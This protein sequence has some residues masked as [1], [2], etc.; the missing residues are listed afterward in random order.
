WKINVVG[1]KNVSKLCKEFKAFLIYVSTDYVFKGDKGM[2]GEEEETDPINYY[3]FTK[4]EGEKIV[5]GLGEF[6]IART[7]VIYGSKPASGKTNFALWL[8]EKLRKEEAV[9]VVSDQ[10]NSPTLNTNLAEMLLEIAER[11]LSGIYHLAGATRM[12][13]Y[14]FAKLV[15]KTFDL[16]KDLIRPTSMESLNWVAKRPRD[17]SLNVSKAMRELR[18]KPKEIKLALNELKDEMAKE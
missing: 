13:R 15:A 4:L 16:S 1:T 3:G 7:S 18:N 6:C 2:Y 10:Y 8:I 5:K 14:E 11:R 17:S 9:S 12:S